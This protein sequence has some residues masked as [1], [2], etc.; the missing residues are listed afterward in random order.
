MLLNFCIC[1]AKYVI[2]CSEVP[3]A[4]NYVKRPLTSLVFKVAIQIRNNNLYV[5]NEMET[6]FSRKF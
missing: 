3:K 5:L 6:T 2:A 1:L 4:K